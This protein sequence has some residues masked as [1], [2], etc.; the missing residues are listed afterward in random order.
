MSTIGSINS[1]SIANVMPPS[2]SA[3]SLSADQK[4]AIKSALN[5]FDSKNLSAS[6]AKK[7]SSEFK[8][9]GIQPGR[10]L[11][12][13]MAAA[14]FDAKQVGTLAFGQADPA[15]Q[16]NA[17]GKTLAVV[18]SSLSELKSLV[19]FAGAGSA[20][21]GQSDEDISQATDSF[22]KILFSQS[23][24]SRSADATHKKPQGGPP[25]GG[26]QGGNPPPPPPTGNASYKD[27]S[28]IAT[29]L[30]SLIS[31]LTSSAESVNSNTSTGEEESQVIQ[32]ASSLLK[33]TG[34]DASSA[35]LQSFM[36]ILQKNISA[37]IQDKGNLV[38]HL[39]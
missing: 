22:L 20:E 6:D 37:T 36:Q 11:E 39:T 24:E 25:P 4:S 34:I 21:A 35:N 9:L 31:S 17:A 19:S 15:M 33:A 16:G 10:A 30:S 26:L 7:I 38:D 12:G 14:G 1:N 13:A 2:R 23:A 32:S 18:S 8:K 27:D 28:D 3:G 5:N 29:F